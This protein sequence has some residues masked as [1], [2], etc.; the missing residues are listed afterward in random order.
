MNGRV[1]VWS[2]S[3]AA[4]LRAPIGDTMVCSA[5]SDGQKREHTG[6]AALHDLNI[7]HY[8]GVI[9]GLY[10]ALEHRDT[11]GYRLPLCRGAAI[12]AAEAS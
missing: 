3:V 5:G 7:S 6:P 4:F 11:H 9:P 2:T 10:P 8:L 12:G 1:A